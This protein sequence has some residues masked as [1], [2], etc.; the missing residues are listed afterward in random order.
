MH[1]HIATIQNYVDPMICRAIAESVD[2]ADLYEQGIMQ[3]EDG[4]STGDFDVEHETRYV[5]CGTQFKNPDLVHCLI[6]T[7]VTNYIEPEFLC[8][9]KDWEMPQLLVYPEN[10]GHYKPH[11]DAEQ[12][13]DGVWKRV[14]NRHITMLLYLDENYTGGEL[15]F[16]DYGITMNPK[17]GQLLVFPSNRWYIHGVEPLVGG[18]RRVLVCWLTVWGQ[19]TIAETE[20]ER[21]VNGQYPRILLRN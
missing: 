15:T 2:T 5:M 8:S 18:N 11:A 21:I 16:P 14:T 1:Q 13:I 4:V 10:G 20:K 7:I 9:V 12:C 19:E 3:I 17:I 6:Q